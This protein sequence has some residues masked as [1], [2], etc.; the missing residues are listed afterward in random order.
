MDNL[1][2]AYDEVYVYSMSRPR[3]IL[4]HVVDAFVVQTANDESE[5]IGVIFGLVGLYLHVERQFSGS[6]VQRVHME[7]G[8]EKREWP[9]VE[10]TG[11]LGRMTVLDVLNVS[12]GPQRDLA[13]DEWCRSVWKAC[14][15]NRETIIGLL[16]NYQVI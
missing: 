1:R 9:S 6:E 7:L 12:D 14:A 4:Q 15:S 5:L 13:I 10:L 16:R 2:A 3:F 8:R 11:C